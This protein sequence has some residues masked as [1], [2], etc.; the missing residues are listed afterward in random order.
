MTRPPKDDYNGHVETGGTTLPFMR[1][2]LSA[3]ATLSVLMVIT[4]CGG[5]ND[6]PA[7]AQESPQSL[8]SASPT[9]AAGWGQP[10][11][12][13]GHTITI[14]KPVDQ[15][16]ESPDS[17]LATLLTTVTLQAGATE[18]GPTTLDLFAEDSDHGEVEI[19]NP[20]ETVIPAGESRVVD[21]VQL[22]V[23]MA[24]RYGAITITLVSLD[25]T[26]TVTWTREAIR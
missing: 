4:G 6:Q 26:K 18:L 20:V 8:A 21:G 7:V 16:E 1:S 22:N 17:D 13:D 23:D 14:A 24:Y 25:G 19:S 15:T 10:Q 11:T 2:T 9:I 3:A 12:V 5:G